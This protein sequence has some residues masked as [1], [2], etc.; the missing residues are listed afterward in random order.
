MLYKQ[1]FKTLA[2][3]QKRAAFE[4][5]H[6]GDHGNINYR[7]FTVRCLED[8]TPDGQ[9]YA[10]GRKYAYRIE[11]TLGDHPTDPRTLTPR[12]HSFQQA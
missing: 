7:F 10:S 6:A 8:G 2:G 12:P 1:I 11:R 4:R 5:A 3:A 9:P